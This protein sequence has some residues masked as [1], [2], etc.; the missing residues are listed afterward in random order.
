[1]PLKEFR[2]LRLIGKGGYGAV[3]QVTRLSDNHDYA[4]KVLNIAKMNLQERQRAL[5]EIRFLASIRHPCVISYY[6][7][8]IESSKLFIVMEFA[9]KGDL[10]ARVKKRRSVKPVR[11]YSEELVWAVLIQI[12]F[13]LKSFHDASIVHRDIKS[14]NIFITG[15]HRVK[16]GDLGVAKLIEADLTKTMI[17]TPYYQSP[18]IWIQTPYNTKIDIWSFG[19]VMYELATFQYPY[20]AQDYKS[21]GKKVLQGYHRPIPEC[22]SKELSDVIEAMMVAEPSKRPSI[23]DILEMETVKSRFSLIPNIEKIMETSFSLEDTMTAPPD[24]PDDNTFE[25]PRMP[26]PTDEMGGYTPPGLSSDDEDANVEASTGFSDQES[27]DDAGSEAKAAP[28]QEPILPPVQQKAVPPQQPQ[29][30]PQ[31][32]IHRQADVHAS[33]NFK[34]P[35]GQAFP[36]IMQSHLRSD[37]MKSNFSSR[38]PTMASNASVMVRNQA[39]ATPIRIAKHRSP[40]SVSHTDRAGSSPSRF[41]QGYNEQGANVKPKFPTDPEVSFDFV[42]TIRSPTTFS[43]FSLP[44]SNNIPPLEPSPV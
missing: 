41:G 38:A 21:L 29:V 39:G 10:H 15:E 5:N 3:Y 32:K 17:G 28:P 19:C 44:S 12:A 18:E 40:R 16:I 8:F 43:M 13:G 20:N 34:D 31:P 22:Y 14:S 42:S 37:R 1:M 25:F 27:V 33:E 11:R 7:A 23:D 6:E 35:Q 24:L 9:S 2:V 4:L 36:P 26:Y 30:H